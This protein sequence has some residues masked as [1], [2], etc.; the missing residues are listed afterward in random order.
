MDVGDRGYR[1][2]GMMNRKIKSD[3][4]GAEALSAG[5]REN[6]MPMTSTLRFGAIS[7]ELTSSLDSW[8]PW[9]RTQDRLRVNH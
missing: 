8:P 7:G 2:R 6:K 3:N 4:G 9:S 5:R 1:R